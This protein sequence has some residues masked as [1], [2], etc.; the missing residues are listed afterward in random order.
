MRKI[1][2]Y[3]ILVSII[4]LG[5]SA[6]ADDIDLPSTGDLWDNWSNSQDNYRESKNVS[7]ED[8][9]KAINK[10]KE[11]TNKREAK[12]KKKQIPKGEEFH[13]SNESE[14]IKNEVSEDSLPVVSIPIGL[15]IDNEVLPVGHY[16]VKGEKDESGNV[17]LKFYQAHYLMAQV[18]AVETN[19][20]FDEDAITFAKWLSEDDNHI[21]VI[22]GT[23]D[24]NVYAII[25]TQEEENLTNF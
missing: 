1:F 14:I 9:D 3:V 4:F 8:F 21:K 20:D 11:K 12:L 25:Q 18:P 22:F 24:I 6:Y 19:D 23:M 2:S 13:Q 16:Q 7:D 10:I 15:I 5:M 17:V